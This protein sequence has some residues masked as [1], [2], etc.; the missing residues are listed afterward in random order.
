MRTAPPLVL[1]TLAATAFGGP[2]TQR[3]HLSDEQNPVFGSDPPELVFAISEIAE[4]GSVFFSVGQE[5]DTIGHESLWRWRDGAF[6][7]VFDRQTR[8]QGLSPDA[9]LDRPYGF[10]VSDSGA[11]TFEAS[12]RYDNGDANGRPGIGIFSFADGEITPI[13]VEG[14]TA[15]GTNGGTFWR[16]GYF[17]H[18]T[19]DSMGSIFWAGVDHPTGVEQIGA[20]GLWRSDDRGLSLIAGTG[21]TAPGIDGAVITHVGTVTEPNRFGEMA[22]TI[23]YGTPGGDDG[24]GVWMSDDD[25]LTP[26]SFTGVA[27]PGLDGATV[28]YAYGGAINSTGTMLYK[29]ELNDYDVPAASGIILPEALYVYD[30]GTSRLI[31]ATG[32]VAPGTGGARFDLLSSSLLSRE[33][34][35]DRGD[36]LMAATL[37]TGDTRADETNDSGVWIDRGD[38]LELFLRE[39]DAVP[40]DESST[41]DTLRSFHMNNAGDIVFTGSTDPSNSFSSGL[42]AYLA[43]EQRFETIVSIGDLFDVSVA[44]DGSDLRTVSYIQ[45]GYQKLVLNDNRQL[46]FELWFTD[47]TNGTFVTTIPAP[48]AIAV[49]AGA[50]LL[51]TRSRGDRGRPR[52]ARTGARSRGGA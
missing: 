34:M 8:V 19:T 46:L 16:W 30:D 36:I 22:M 15:P 27:A 1:M 48:G 5:D 31:A 37:I 13:A 39:G 35:N 21:Q 32:S 6:T 41:F 51:I 7:A 50:A 18:A 28:A 47:G 4:D 20:T 23:T 12:I 38:G 44:Q 25:G 2:S 42:W 10:S 49:F 9:F 43:D 11:Y 17:P 52:P 45:D 14:D 3:L 26:V 24:F 29:V 33:T 40:G